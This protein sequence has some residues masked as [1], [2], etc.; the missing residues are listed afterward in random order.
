MK[1]ISLHISPPSSPPSPSKPLPRSDIGSAPSRGVRK[2]VKNALSRSFRHISH[3]GHHPNPAAITGIDR[4]ATIA[5]A[6]ATTTTTA[7]YSPD[8]PLLDVGDVFDALAI[9]ISLPLTPKNKSS[10]DTMS[11]NPSSAG[12]QEIPKSTTLAVAAVEVAHDVQSA[13]SSRTPLSSPLASPLVSEGALP[14]TS[15]PV[16]AGVDHAAHPSSD[17]RFPHEAAETPL[18]VAQPTSSKDKHLEEDVHPEDATTGTVTSAAAA[19]NDAHPEAQV[20]RIEEQ[21]TLDSPQFDAAEPGTEARDSVGDSPVPD[22]PETF[23][24]DEPEEAS[25]SEPDEEVLDE[26]VPS[27]LHVEQAREPVL[28]LAEDVSLAQSSEQPASVPVAKQ[29]ASPPAAEKPV[30]PP[31]TTVED[32]DEDDEE[33]ELYLPGLTL[34]T[35]F[36]PIPNTDPLSTLLIKYIP[37]ERRPVRDVS[38]NW[39]GADFNMLVMTNSWRALAKMARDRLVDSNPDELD[40]VLSL[41]YLRL[42]CL[43]RLRLF[44]QTSAECTSLFTVLSNV[45][46]Q[47]A[48]QWLFEKKVP[49]ELEVLYA[50]LRYWAGD[51]MGYLDALSVLLRDCKLKARKA[52]EKSD[53]VGSGMWQERGARVCLIIASQLVEMKDFSAAAKLLEPLCKQPGNVTSPHVQSAVGRIYLLGGYISM[54]SKHFAEVSRDVT[55]DPV[56]KAMNDAMLACANGDW[57]KASNDLNQIL[58][59]DPEHFVAVNNLAV[60]FLSQGRIQD[61]IRLLE[62]TIKISPSSALATEPLLF[63]LSTMY[64]LRSTAG[65]DKKRNL[66]IEVAQWAG[67]GLR[68]TCLKMPST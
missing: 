22:A 53:T 18:S 32:D 58:T 68:T 3:I 5:A 29:P 35:M 40:L 64:E 15:L 21:P 8:D 56:L 60:A 27:G 57:T 47:S 55:A 48:R 19:E 1:H 7:R 10:S 11:S 6:A 44:N 26:T 45:K 14:P 23:F 63:N 4:H 17:E 49:F 38:G 59:A 25:V 65:A 12:G 62:E 43:A 13:C 42:S 41:W 46:P 9:P 36:L 37:P 34:P 31:P 67:D 51:H 66:L 28:A 30:P 33:P 39:Q 24:D 20:E 16:N 2:I 52:S 50:R 61:G 54:A